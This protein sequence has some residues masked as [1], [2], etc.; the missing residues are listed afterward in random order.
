MSA[1]IS[2]LAFGSAFPLLDAAAIAPA[3]APMSGEFASIL[4]AFCWAV[5]AVTFASAGRMI[6]S[7]HV[8]RIRLALAAVLVGIGIALF[9]VVDAMFPGL[10][11][12]SASMDVPITQILLLVLSGFLGLVFGDACYFE[13]LVVLGARRAALLTMLTP[14]FVALLIVPVMGETM[15]L[16]EVGGMV[17][18][19]GGV[20]WVI[21][22][23]SKV[24]GE[25][26][27]GLWRGIVLGV[28]GCVGQ[29]SGFLVAKAGL[30][31]AKAHS[32][33][34]EWSDL[35]VVVDASGVGRAGT[36]VHAMVGTLFRMGS[37]AVILM[38][39]SMYK[40]EVRQ[41]MGSMRNTKAMA[42]L[43][44]GTLMG[45]TIGV[46]LAMYALAHSNTA[47]ASTIIAT[48][49]IMVIPLV[50]IF[51][52]ERVSWR[53]LLGS[54]VALIGVA[55]LMGMDDEIARWFGG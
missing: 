41:V 7:R 3:S 50:V 39:I 43:S 37:A 35:P 38:M 10:G 8:N 36:E 26:S 46:S 21:L 32:L 19:L 27:E 1:G 18:T 54:T 28:L 5:G 42:T 23:R 2:S 40:G 34:V 24:E 29:A 49:P 20:A 14:V 52:R 48:M 6:G 4:T 15:T 16:V 30:G 13:C 53:A 51:Q 9:P 11:I 47:I 17:L 25:T 45:P 44:L 33:I 55:I 22:E 12:G 31:S